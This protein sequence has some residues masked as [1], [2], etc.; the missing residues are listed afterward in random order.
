MRWPAAKRRARYTVVQMESM[1][2]CSTRRKWRRHTDGEAAAGTIV[3][4]VGMKTDDGSIVAVRLSDVS[5]KAQTL[6]TTVTFGQRYTSCTALSYAIHV[7]SLGLHVPYIGN[8][9]WND[10]E[11]T[12]VLLQGC[13]RL[14][15]ST[16]H[17]I[18]L[19]A[20]AEIATQSPDSGLCLTRF[21]IAAHIILD[22]V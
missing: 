21:T 10:N 12:I 11:M 5:V 22:C 19:H 1:A 2:I 14:L 17:C 15:C 20:C 16:F 8:N 4:E 7:R 3:I 18:K 9:G 6:S 13:L